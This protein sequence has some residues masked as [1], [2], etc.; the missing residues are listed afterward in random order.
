M[1]PTAPN[2]NQLQTLIQRITTALVRGQLSFAEQELAMLARLSPQ[3]SETYR[4]RGQL[5][6][7]QGRL[8]E[9]ERALATAQQAAPRDV[10][11]L[12]AVAQLQSRQGRFDRMVATLEQAIKLKPDHVPA[13]G[14]L[15]NARRQQGQPR[16]A[17]KILERIPKSPAAGISAAWAHYDL[18]EY[19]RVIEVI[20]PVLNQAANPVGSPAG[21][22]VGNQPGNPLGNAAASQAAGVGD[23]GPVNR[24]QAHQIRGLALEKLGRYEAAVAAFTAANST[25]PLRFQFDRYQAWLHD[26]RAQYS[27]AAWPTLARS[28]NTSS[29]PVFISALPGSGVAMVGAIIASHPEAADAG[30]VDMI[31]RQVEGLMKP[32][33][34]DSWPAITKDLLS[35]EL[36]NGLATRYLEATNVVGPNA[37]RTVDKHLYNWVYLG[38]LGQTFPNARA[39]HIERDPVDLGI[40]CFERVAATVAPWSADLTHLGTVIRLHSELMEHWKALKPMPILT[41]S[42]ERL[43]RETEAETKRI[44]EFLELPWDPA[45]LAALSSLRRPSENDAGFQLDDAS[46]GRGAR[47]GAALNPLRKAIAGEV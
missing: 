31:R 15:A 35:T 33:L 16:L 26:V 2:Q 27:A 29:R 34:A 17:L 18:G 7:M 9:A 37:V 25:I 38:L 39:I 22:P 47:F 44:I 13:L 43:L 20:N 40:S 41:V 30:D 23:I 36:L 45:C 42:Y 5:R 21:Q 12:M 4:L 8:A 3:G 46:I 1:F 6:T 28:T 11:I 24:S 19:E 14:L 32:E 10:G